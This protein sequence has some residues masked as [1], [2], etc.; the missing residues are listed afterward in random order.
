MQNFTFFFSYKQTK[1]PH[2]TYGK[3]IHK[4]TMCLSSKNNRQAGIPT[5]GKKLSCCCEA[6]PVQMLQEK[7]AGILSRSGQTHFICDTRRSQISVLLLDTQI[8]E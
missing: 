3:G 5:G 8:D 2:T 6:S 7:Q 1:N 4:R